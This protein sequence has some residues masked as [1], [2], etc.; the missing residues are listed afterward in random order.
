MVE[1][2]SGFYINQ[3]DLRYLRSYTLIP[4]TVLPQPRNF[5]HQWLTK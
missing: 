4:N 3:I 2:Q 5:L 1:V